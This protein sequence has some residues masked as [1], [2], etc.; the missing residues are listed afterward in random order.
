MRQG[1]FEVFGAGELGLKA[2][3]LNQYSELLANVGVTIPE[4]IVIATGVFNQLTELLNLEAAPEE[5]EK[6]DCPDFLLS[7]NQGILDRLEIGRPYAIRSS[8]L[9][10]RGGT[11]IYKSVFF[12]PTGDRIEDLKNLWRCE[13]TVYASEFTL[14]AKLWREKNNA[15]AGMAILIQPV[16]GF[17]FKEHFLPALAGVAYT[18]LNGLPTIRVVIGLGT[19][20]VNGGGVV[21]NYRP[22]NSYY[23]GKELWEQKVAEA[24]TAGGVI[25]EV[26]PHYE[27]IQ[28]GVDFKSFNDLFD[29]LEK[30]QK[31]GGF[32][33]EWVISEG[34]VFV[35]QCA[36]HNDRPTTD[37]PFDMSSHFLLM[38]GE[39]V[40]HS[41]RAT[42]KAIIYARMWSSETAQA[43]EHLNR[44]VR[45]Y[46]L[47]VPQHALSLMAEEGFRLAFRHFSNALAVVEKQMS[48]DFEEEK[49]RIMAGLPNIDHTSGKGATHFAQ[50]CNR[51]DIL[52]IGGEFDSTPLIRLPGVIQYR[53]DAGISMWKTTVEVF[54]DAKKK[55]GFLYVSKGAEKKNY[56]L[57]Q[58]QDW[59]DVLRSVANVINDLSN[60]EL[61]SPGVSGHFYN[62][63]YAIAPDDDPIEFDSFKLDEVIVAECGIA[64][65]IKSIETVIANGQYFGWAERHAEHVWEEGGLKEYLEE[66]LEHLKQQ[67]T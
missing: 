43:L 34:K 30:L 19:L 60:P 38:K 29:T 55:E 4:G 25:G 7:I 15:P 54:A 57:Y 45:D 56:S 23:F 35:V 21:Y 31:Q 18:S 14:D 58:V 67:T 20:A 49:L 8:A 13:A 33:F 1:I 46:L 2:D 10:E 3:D 27:E 40:L 24:I 5:I 17:R 59:S 66:L 37:L 6:R 44:N 53:R 61:V 11:G 42:C 22:D 32:F 52:F 62:V 16:V 64:G 50:L 47:I 12:W 26:S 9:S 63:H 65:I 48:V 28:A 51:A 39:D 36:A 41:G